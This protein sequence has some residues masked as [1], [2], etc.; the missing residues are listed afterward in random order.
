MNQNLHSNPN[1]A[2]QTFAYQFNSNPNYANQM[3][4]N[5]CMSQF[6][7]NQYPYQPPL[8]N[9]NNFNQQPLTNSIYTT[10][11]PPSQYNTNTYNTNQYQKS[12]DNEDKKETEHEFLTTKNIIDISENENENDESEHNIDEEFVEDLTK[13]NKDLIDNILT[14]DIKTEVTN[15]DILNNSRILKGKT[16]K[17][18]EEFEADLQ[19]YQNETFQ[20]FT[21]AWSGKDKRVKEKLNQNGFMNTPYLQNI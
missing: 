9:H 3:I 5:Q 4:T 14:N 18:L 15:K 19:I 17:S 10:Q 7:Q 8:T 21:I 11:I 2:N 20:S 6:P 1:Y 12:K 13:R 16:Y